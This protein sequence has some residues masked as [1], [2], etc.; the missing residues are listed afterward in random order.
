MPDNAL[1]ASGHATTAPP[2]AA[3]NSRRPMGTVIRPSPARC[4]NATIPRHRRADF[5]FGR[6]G[7]PLLSSSDLKDP[8]PPPCGDARQEPLTTVILLRQRTPPAQPTH[9]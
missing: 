8:P 2:S 6:A 5:T 9:H 7:T 1:A 4:V 3:S